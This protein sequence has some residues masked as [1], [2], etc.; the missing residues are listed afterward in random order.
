MIVKLE[1]SLNKCGLFGGVTGESSTLAYKS[2]GALLVKLLLN[3]LQDFWNFWK[4][5][6]GLVWS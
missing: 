4:P 5:K 6:R 1:K 2:M 3:K